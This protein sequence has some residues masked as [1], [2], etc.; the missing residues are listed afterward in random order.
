MTLNPMPGAIMPAAPSSAPSPL[1][2]H[3][4]ARSS[5]H[6]GL[7][8]A[9][10][11]SGTADAMEA[12]VVWSEL[13]KQLDH[14]KA[15]EMD[16]RK[17]LFAHFFPAPK[18]GVNNRDLNAGYVMKGTPTT[19]VKILEDQL[20]HVTAK[21]KERGVDV[22]DFLKWKPTLDAKQYGEL[23]KNEE[24]DPLKPIGSI[25]REMILT[26]PGAPKLEIVLPAKA[27][28]AT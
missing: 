4:L 1:P 20:A 16:F 11:Q 8:L 13:E 5:S 12:A 14:F 7:M 22:G 3:E 19:N 6:L 27:R 2:P 21:L 15:W 25:L 28:K 18:A 24:N 9:A 10:L 23:V 17:A 26:T